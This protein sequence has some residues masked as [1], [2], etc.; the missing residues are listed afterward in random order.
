MKQNQSFGV[1]SI[2]I[3]SRWCTFIIVLHYSWNRLN[4]IEL[5]FCPILC[6]MELYYIK[7]YTLKIP[8]YFFLSLTHITHDTLV[9]LAFSNQFLIQESSTW[10]ISYVTKYTFYFL[11]WFIFFLELWRICTLVFWTRIFNK[12]IH[13]EILSSDGPCAY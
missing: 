9:F 1:G 7:W 10:G 4:K 13:K 5:N 11:T 6:S 12:I 8:K 3:V 2:L